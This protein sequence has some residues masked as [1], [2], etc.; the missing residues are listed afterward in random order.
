MKFGLSLLFLTLASPL[1]GGV[2]AS[3][4]SFHDLQQVLYG[5][6]EGSLGDTEVTLAEECFHES[7]VTMEK[8]EVAIQ[9]IEQGTA[10]SVKEGI[11]LL[12]KALH[13]VTKDMQDCEGVAIDLAKLLGMTLALSHPVHFLFHAGLNI[14]VN[15]VEITEELETAIVDWREDPPKYFD[16]GVNMGGILQLV[17]AGTDNNDDDD[18][19]NVMGRFGNPAVMSS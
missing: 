9:E 12:G 13:D 7:E 1:L 2:S 18:P 5:V 6:I 14:V 10:Q 11:Q 4:F 15:H 3:D 8:V 17:F 19:T 16:F